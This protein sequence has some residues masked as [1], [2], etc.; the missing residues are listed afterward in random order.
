MSKPDAR[1]GDDEGGEVARRPCF[2]RAPPAAPGRAC[3]P[4]AAAPS[5]AAWIGPASTL[6]R[7]SARC[8]PGRARRTSTSTRASGRRPGAGCAP[9]RCSCRS[10]SAA[11]GIGLILTRRAALLQHHPGQV[12]FPGGK[13]DPERRRRRSPR[14]CAR[15]EEEIG[16]EAR[17]QSSAS[18]RPHETVTG[19]VV[20]PFVGLVAAGFVPR[21]D[22]AEVD[23]VFEV[24]LAFV[25]DPANFR[26]AGTGVAGAA[27]GTTTSSRRA[28]TTSGARRRG[29]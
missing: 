26:I 8:G 27:C 1:D 10:S 2:P 20:T 9:P 3:A 25:L 12:A 18:S 21:I 23:E 14:R 28:R 16:L 22:R 15:R 17:R 13:Q 6:R 29:C 4:A 7:S 5:S 19:F 11:P 24:P